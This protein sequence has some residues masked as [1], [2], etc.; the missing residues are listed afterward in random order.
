M[1]GDGFVALAFGAGIFAAVNPCGF[2]MLP[3][4]LSFFLGLEGAEADRR[5]TV[6]RSLLVAAA[7]AA[8]FTA[9]FGTLGILI[10]GFSIEVRHQLPWVSIG[11]GALLLV[12][13]VAMLFGFEPVLKLPKL[14]RGGQDRGLASMFLFGVSYAIASVGCTIGPF[15]ISVV[16][17]FSSESTL[18]G[19]LSFLAYAAGMALVLVTLTVSLALARRSI[20][21]RLRQAL[22]WVQ[23][24]AGGLL[25]LAGAYT[26]YYGWY[27]LR[28]YE[29]DASGGAVAQRSLD[30]NASLTNWLDRIGTTRLGV[31]MAIV[32]AG[33]VAWAWLAT[34]HEQ[35]EGTPAAPDRAETAQDHDGGQDHAGADEHAGGGRGGCDEHAGG[36]RAGRDEPADHPSGQPT[37]TG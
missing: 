34:R 29:G 16:A 18:E 2:A 22:P 36:D 9:V 1:S 3:A 21:T 10:N 28:V 8:G 13:G 4:Y 11:I 5:T 27:E 7:V 32:V 25:V 30:L 26:A 31:G 20:V 33:L 37:T 15:L 17:A 19:M 23:R 14:D 6:R 35:G 12:L 24:T